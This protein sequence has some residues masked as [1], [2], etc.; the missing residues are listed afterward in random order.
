[1]ADAEAQLEMFVARFSDE[2]QTLIRDLRTALQRRFPHAKELVW[3]NYNFMVIGY[4]ANERPSSAVVSLAAGAN[5]VGLSF[6]RGADLADPDAVL[7]GEGSQNRYIR[8]PDA[9]VLQRPAV[10]ALI[11]QAEAQAPVPM[12]GAGGNELIIRSVSA[13]QRPRRKD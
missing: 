2:H 5:G 4:C 7:L 8:L 11:D 9:E 6:Y 3:D 10:A 1:M 13:K 12:P